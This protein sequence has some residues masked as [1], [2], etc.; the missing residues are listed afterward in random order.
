[1]SEKPC[2]ADCQTASSLTDAETGAELYRTGRENGV[3][4]ASPLTQATV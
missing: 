2:L 4:N 3:P 1:M